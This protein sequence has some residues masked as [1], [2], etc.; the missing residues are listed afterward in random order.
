MILVSVNMKEFDA[1]LSKYFLRV[2]HSKSIVHQP[3][4]QVNKSNGFVFA[5]QSADFFFDEIRL[6]F[7]LFP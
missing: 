2:M 7:V 5:D 6:N 1:E 4:A 3:C